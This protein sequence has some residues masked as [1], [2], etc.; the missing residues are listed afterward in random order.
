M[1]DINLDALLFTTRKLLVL[2]N[3]DV[4]CSGGIGMSV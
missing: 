2:A 1:Y 4:R 3:V